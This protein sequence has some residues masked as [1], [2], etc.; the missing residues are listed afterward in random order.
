MRR[1]N[2]KYLC[3]GL[4]LV[5]MLSQSTF[6]Y[7]P[8]TDNSDGTILDGATNLFWQKCSAGQ[9]TLASNFTDCA[10]GSAS[11]LTWADALGYCNSLALAG[12][13]WRLPNISEL[14]SILELESALA[15]PALDPAYF[16]NSVYSYW[17]STSHP[18]QHTDS[19]TGLPHRSKAMFF[20]F[21]TNAHLVDEAQKSTSYSVRCVSLP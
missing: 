21:R 16:P 19:D 5:L 8:Y 15:T 3:L 6:A 18:S 9:G 14:S 10:S 7:G 20:S 12:R 13:S 1:L 2:N 11:A 17:S 4:P